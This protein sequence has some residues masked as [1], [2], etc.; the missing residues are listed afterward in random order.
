M[1]RNPFVG[2]QR[3]MQRQVRLGI[4]R[5]SP[6][7]PLAPTGAVLVGTNDGTTGAWVSYGLL[8]VTTFAEGFRLA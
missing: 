7:A 4:A 6:P 2:E 1:N 3:E 8:D 5:T